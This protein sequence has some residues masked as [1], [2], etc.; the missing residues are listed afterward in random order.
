MPVGTASPRDTGLSDPVQA[1][2]NH[3]WLQWY[4]PGVPA[5]VDVPDTA[6]AALLSEA[7]IRHPRRPAIRFLGRSL[8]YRDLDES[9]N[10]F[11]NHLRDLGVRKGDRV[12]LLLPNCPQMVIAAYGGLRAGAVLVPSSPLAAERELRQAWDEAGVRV[13]VCLSAFYPK[14]HRIR[15]D[16]PPLEHVVVARI[17]DYFP[18]LLRLLFTLLREG[19]EGHRVRLPADGH[20]YPFDRFLA[21]GSPDDPNVPLA[22][23]D[24]ALLQPTGGTTGTPKL[25]MLSHH[26]LLANALQ[27]RAWFV[28]LLEPDGSDIL[29]GVIPLFHIYGITTVLNLAVAIGGTMLLQPRVVL[30]DVLKSID[31]ERPHFF[32]GI[33]TLYLA[34]NDAPAVSRYD[35]RSLKAAI[36]G[37]APLPHEVQIEFERLTGAKLVEGYGLT[38]ASPVT[39]CTPV[40][41]RRKIGSIGLPLPGTDAAVF[42][43]DT[44]TRTLPPGEIGEL[45]VRG[46]QVMRGY[47]RGPDET[48][49]VLRDGWLFTGDLAEMDDEGF[50]RI[51]DRKKDLIISGGLN[52][53]PREVE[54]ALYEHHKVHK[55]AVA[56]I[57]DV[58][59]GEAVKAYIVLEEGEMATTEEMIGH[60][61]DRLARYKVPKFVE[62]RADLPE[63]MLGKVLRR[64]LREEETCRGH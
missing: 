36:S 28:N 22:G 38:E 52:V 50:F 47:W 61:R 45:A 10:R 24:L 53:Y 49:D 13:V 12:A 3:P 62:F 57:P 26:N 17:K 2:R 30:R 41:G 31:R 20:T 9:V 1:P 25:A 56:G 7:A 42:D 18:P 44:G 64:R 27:I 23:D 19:P 33:P 55:V 29:L 34:V 48:H 32:P 59:W 5:T 43:P 54:E 39:H 15:Q 16:L 51:V 37:A 11:A 58:R 8:V 46:P 6:L 35:L 40:E 21:A 14:V 60:C 63:N 4:D